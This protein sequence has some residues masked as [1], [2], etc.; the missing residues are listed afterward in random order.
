MGGDVAG[1]LPALLEVL[2]VVLLRAPERARGGDLGHDRTGKPA[3]AVERLLRTPRRRL[4]GRIQI[5]DR[6]AVLAANV[7][8]LAVDR[9]GVVILPEHLQ[10]SVETHL[11]G[12][13]LDLHHLGVAGA[14]GTD[15]L[16]GRVVGHAARVAHGGGDDAG[17]LPEC[18]LGSPEAAHGKDG[19]VHAAYFK[20]PWR[21]SPS[22][23]AG[24]GKISGRGE[25]GWLARTQGGREPQRNWMPRED[26]R[27][28]EDNARSG[29]KNGVPAF[30]DRLAWG[31]D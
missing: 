8:T 31:L 24:R 6:G 27:P 22:C 3:A 19:L 12:I 1:R 21:Q 11:R 20:P 14:V 2:L 30:P 17:H 7:R 18:R 10:Q 23:P 5:E 26:S 13:E 28:T 16:V 15:L 4:L 25:T 9:R 29:L